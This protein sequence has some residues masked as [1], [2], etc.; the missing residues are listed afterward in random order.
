[1][2]S[3]Q[4]DQSEDGFTLLEMLVVMTIV[5]VVFAGLSNTIATRNTTPTVSDMAKDVQSL[6]YRARSM[7]ISTGVP[8]RV[9]IDLDGKVFSY[10]K[11]NPI[12]LPDT[13]GL[14][15][16]TGQEM[17]SATGA[18]ELLFLSDGSSS[19]MDVELSDN[20]ISEEARQDRRI[21]KLRV[22]WLTGLPSIVKP[23]TQ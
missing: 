20:A 3:E 2:K 22:N 7:A 13:V 23:T 17:I 16:T 5:M 15:I 11:L 4:A 19:G 14:R 6:V 9:W 1:M 8:Q 10:E 12:Q 21:A 18:I